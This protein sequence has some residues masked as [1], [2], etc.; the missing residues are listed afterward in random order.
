MKKKKAA[1]V[2]SLVICASM[3]VGVL[4]TA[5]SASSFS[6]QSTDNAAPQADNRRE[7]YSSASSA[8]VAETSAYDSVLA[9]TAA[10]TGGESGAGLAAKA[11]ASEQKIIQ[12]LSYQ[13][14]T[15]EF[16]KSVE[17]VQKLCNELGGYIQ[18]SSVDGNGAVD[19]VSM[20]YAYF[21]LRVPRE[22]L[23]QMKDSAE[24]IGTVRNFS[25][26]SE[27]VTEQYFDTESR[28]KSLRAQEERLLEMMKS[29]GTMEEMIQVE[30][31]LADVTYQIEQLT[32]ELKR[33][34]S[35]V[36]YSTVT[37]DLQEVVEP[38]EVR[39]IPVTLGEKINNQFKA[40]L[41]SLG[42]FGEG[43]LIVVIGG[44]PVLLLLA[45]IAVVIILIVR[46]SSKKAKAKREAHLREAAESSAQQEGEN[47]EQK[48]E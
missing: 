46:K 37:I 32:G 44:L 34:D 36:D 2:L 33:Y 35:L 31:A 17:T 18:E 11:A 24:M 38:T 16:D 45:V 22:K 12:N 43:L 23:G 26:T 19:R 39:Q 9:D 13:I 27:N 28:L 3:A 6:G 30:R 20:R 8:A 4:F 40:S 42:N 1:G 15:L 21:V 29:T 48:D 14:E 5:C 25:T 10:D 47:E 7:S 41:R